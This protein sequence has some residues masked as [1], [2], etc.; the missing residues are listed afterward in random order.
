MLG[1]HDHFLT[2]RA[3]NKAGDILETISLVKQSLINSQIHR[4]RQTFSQAID[5][6]A[7]FYSQKNTTIAYPFTLKPEIIVA[8]RP[9]L[10]NDA[11]P[12]AFDNS[13]EQHQLSESILA[14]HPQW[15][16]N[17]IATKALSLF[18]ISLFSQQ[19]LQN[20]LL[21][22]EHKPAEIK[23]GIK[24][25]P[26]DAV[27]NIKT[28][29]TPL[30]SQNMTAVK[31]ILKENE[32][33]LLDDFITFTEKEYFSNDSADDILKPELYLNSNSAFQFMPAQ[34]NEIQGLLKLSLPTE[35]KSHTSKFLSPGQVIKLGDILLKSVK[36][37]RQQVQFEII[38]NIDNLVQVR[39]YN[40]EGT[41]IS[42][43]LELKQVQKNKA[44]L[45]L[46][47]N[48]KIDSIKLILAQNSV[49]KDYSFSFLLP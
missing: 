13:L 37:T 18:Y 28:A 42:E 39:L 43:A 45:T 5:S 12:L 36:I 9:L 46:L 7:I 4:F 33:I 10:I 40:T 26:K 14:D 29:I 47:Y 16:G 15:L 38:G 19:G 2:L 35:F 34:K 25:N 44:L 8:A 41:L 3:Y 1:N 11:E 30:I 24:T 49:K 21:S 32:L 6:I 48:D 17:N 27:I 31:V 22:G 20:E 23:Q